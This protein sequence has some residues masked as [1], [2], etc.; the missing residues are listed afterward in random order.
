[1]SRQGKRSALGKH[2]KMGT[3]VYT[4]ARTKNTGGKGIK[5]EKQEG[6][7]RKAGDWADRQDR[8]KNRQKWTDGWAERP[9]RGNGWRGRRA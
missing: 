3:Q 9:D 8:Q 4:Q 1:M 5:T 7:G 2:R 6:T